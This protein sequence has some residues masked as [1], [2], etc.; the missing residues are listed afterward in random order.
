[1]KRN[2]DGSLKS[3]HLRHGLKW[4][5]IWGTLVNIEKMQ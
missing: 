5:V 2:A 3:R 1:M 4:V